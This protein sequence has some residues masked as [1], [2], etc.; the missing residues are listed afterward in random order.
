MKMN[1]SSYEFLVRTKKFVCIFH[2]IF[3]YFWQEEEKKV[4]KALGKI[5]FS[6]LTLLFEYC[7]S[8][9]EK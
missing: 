5:L 8:K 9:D 7:F 4:F 6:Y 1:E 2:V 3:K